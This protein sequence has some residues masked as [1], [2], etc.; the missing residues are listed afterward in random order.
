MAGDVNFIYHQ[1]QTSRMNRLAKSPLNQYRA[2]RIVAM[3]VQKYFY[4][5]NCILREYAPR[6][7]VVL[8]DFRRFS[9]KHGNKVIQTRTCMTR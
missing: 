4:L 1:I 9:K 3:A 7:E 5:D 2:N 8:G 6:G